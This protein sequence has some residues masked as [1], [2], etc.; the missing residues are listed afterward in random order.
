MRTLSSGVL[1]VI[2]LQL[3]CV[4]VRAEAL[5]ERE[6]AMAQH[7]ILA[8]LATSAKLGSAQRC[9]KEEYACAIAD[10]IDLSVSLLASKNSGNAMQALARLLRYELD[11]GLSEDYTCRV[12]DKGARI[13]PFLSR[14]DAQKLRADCEAELTTL[15]S[16]NSKLFSGIGAKG[17][18]ATETSIEQRKKD[19]L[20]AVNAKRKCENG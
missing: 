17:I 2:V 4:G 7:A 8:S 12:L 13:K 19:L 1:A 3:L 6:I 11:A 15:V 10:P 14:L 18:C 16:R 9:V 5:E 20:K